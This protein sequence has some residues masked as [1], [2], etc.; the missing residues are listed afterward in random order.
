MASAPGTP[1]RWELLTSEPRLRCRVIDFSDLFDLF[2]L[3]PVTSLA[4]S[5]FFRP[6]VPLQAF[7]KLCQA[8]RLVR[9]Q[10]R[11]RAV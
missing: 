8:V 11:L 5:M 1:H 6:S 10:L 4:P 3:F 9:A 2:D 7:C